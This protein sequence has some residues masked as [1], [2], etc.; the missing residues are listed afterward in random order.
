MTQKS[1]Q[2]AQK[3]DPNGARTIGVLTK[4]D[5]CSAG[6]ENR[7]LDFPRGKHNPVLKHGWFVLKRPDAPALSGGITREEAQRQ[8]EVYFSTAQPWCAVEPRYRSNYGGQSLV[9]SLSKLL[10][11]VIKRR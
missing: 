11:E 2:L 4:P 10:C 5:R 3:H 6:S 7:W 9:R 1:Y 8:E